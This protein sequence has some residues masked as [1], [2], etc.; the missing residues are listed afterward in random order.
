MDMQRLRHPLGGH[1]PSVA[2]VVA[3]AGSFAKAPGGCR[4]GTCFAK[5]LYPTINALLHHV[6]PKRSEGSYDILQRGAV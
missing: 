2:G 5:T 3:V 4:V 6:I 1:R